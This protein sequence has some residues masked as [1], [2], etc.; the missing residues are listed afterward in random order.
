M[1]EFTIKDR[2]ALI[3]LLKSRGVMSEGQADTFTHALLDIRESAIEIYDDYLPKLQR[4][5]E[6]GASDVEETIWDIREACRHIDYHL[7]DAKLPPEA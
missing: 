4:Q 5:L 2:A 1:R 7:K 6:I 3:E